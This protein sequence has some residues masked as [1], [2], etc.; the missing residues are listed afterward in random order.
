MTQDEQYHRENLHLTFSQRVGAVPLPDLV[1]P[2]HLSK[3]FRIALNLKFREEIN[4]SRA[5]NSL[6]GETRDEYRSNNVIDECYF[7]TKQ[8][9]SK[10]SPMKSV[11]QS[12]PKIGNS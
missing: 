3:P 4:G 11:S 10:N 7:A 12:H 8:I 6:Y 5:Y 1:K 9:C 2:E